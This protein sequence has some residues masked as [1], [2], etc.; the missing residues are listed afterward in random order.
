MRRMLSRLLLAALC[1]TVV[2]SSPYM[3]FSHRAWKEKNAT[4]A[5][6]GEPESEERRLKRALLYDYDRTSRPVLQE[7]DTVQLDV[8]L[9][10]FHLLD[11]DERQQTVRAVYSFRF[12]SYFFFFTSY[13]PNCP[14][15]NFSADFFQSFDP[16]VEFEEFPEI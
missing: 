4:G 14:N 15:P 1:A 8:A 11:T 5:L 10:L 3:P 16:E 2:N 6:N 13:F 12:V 9:S 7:S